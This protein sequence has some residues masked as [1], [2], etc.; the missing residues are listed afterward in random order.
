MA[1]SIYFMLATGHHRNL[2]L[3]FGVG[4]VIAI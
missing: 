1:D 2:S 3:A 4:I